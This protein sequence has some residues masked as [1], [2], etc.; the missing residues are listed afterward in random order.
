DLPSVSPAEIQR[1][2]KK[3]ATEWKATKSNLIYATQRNLIPQ[4]ISGHR[5]GKGVKSIRPGETAAEIHAS[6]ELLKTLMDGGYGLTLDQIRI[7]REC[8][9]DLYHTVINITPENSQRSF[10]RLSDILE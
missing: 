5:G 1:Q 6:R 7:T 9:R 10:N 4:P 3:L 8:A 2:L